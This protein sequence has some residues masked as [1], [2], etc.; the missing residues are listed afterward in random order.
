[1]DILT[2]LDG[3]FQLIYLSMELLFAEGTFF[4]ALFIFNNCVILLCLFVYFVQQ[5]IGSGRKRR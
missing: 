3:I 2:F 5:L 1:M 4:Y